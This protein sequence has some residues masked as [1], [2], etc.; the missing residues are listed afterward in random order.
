M[1]QIY[2][3]PSKAFFLFFLLSVPPAVCHVRAWPDWIIIE[4]ER[5]ILRMIQMK[6]RSDYLRDSSFFSPFASGSTN[7]P[8]SL[9]VCSM[10]GCA[11]G[12]GREVCACLRIGS[13]QYSSRAVDYVFNRQMCLLSKTGWSPAKVKHFQIKWP[14]SGQGPVICKCPPI[15]VWRYA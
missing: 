3:L 15:T 4:V 10:R 7:L 11:K 1:C 2:F 8:S 6:E 13:C 5:K 12:V 9:S 14:F